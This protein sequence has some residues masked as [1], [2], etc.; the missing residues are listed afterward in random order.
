MK[1]GENMGNKLYRVKKGRVVAGVAAG[2]AE[3]FDIDIAV[4]RLVFVVLLFASPLLGLVAYFAAAIIIPERQGTGAADA[5]QCPADGVQGDENLKDTA[6]RG[7]DRTRFFIGAVLLI[8]GVVLLT[9]QIIPWFHARYFWPL[10]LIAA[11]A[12]IILREWRR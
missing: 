11:G 3:Y 2:M 10:L 12:V 9:R 5:A 8:L 7:A 4:M 6:S 1:E